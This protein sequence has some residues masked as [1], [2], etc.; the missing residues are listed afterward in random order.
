MIE[1]KQ[2]KF[3]LLV[4][5]VDIFFKLMG[6]PTPKELKQYTCDLFSLSSLTV[7]IKTFTAKNQIQ[8]VS[9]QSLG[10]NFVHLKAR[11]FK[12]RFRNFGINAISLRRFLWK[13]EKETPYSRLK[14]IIGI[15]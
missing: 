8:Q 6:Y 2:A 10:K 1:L 12:I 14:F 4:N 13:V 11:D 7:F 15:F 3:H 5:I 9:A